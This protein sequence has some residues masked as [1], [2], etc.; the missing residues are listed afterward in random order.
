MNDRRVDPSRLSLIDGLPFTPECLH[1]EHLR[2]RL[3][4][5]EQLVVDVAIPDD[6]TEAVD[7]GPQQVLGVG[8]RG[9]VRHDADAVSVR[10]VDDR[11]IQRRPELFDRPIAIVHPDL[12]Q[13][14]ALGAQLPNVLARLRLGRH[15]KRRIAH[16]HARP[17]V[18]HREAPARG[19]I[20]RAGPRFCPDLERQI[21][22]AGASFENSGDAAVRK[23]VEGI[24]EVSRV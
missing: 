20:P 19:E 7:A 3:Q 2:A 24:E 10:L 13:V 23:A 11:A 22:A 4:Q 18:R 6:V 8:E 5:R 1:E 21:T 14:G 12:D 15:A 9:D 17:R 16:R